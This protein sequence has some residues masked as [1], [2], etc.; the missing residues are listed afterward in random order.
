LDFTRRRVD[1][2]SAKEIQE[3]SQAVL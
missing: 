3:S 1:L 2:V